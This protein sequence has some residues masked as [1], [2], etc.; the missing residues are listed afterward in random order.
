MML[1]SDGEDGTRRGKSTTASL[2]HAKLQG[3]EPKGNSKV[4]GVKEARE[5]GPWEVLR[6]LSQYEIPGKLITL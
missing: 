2:D 3:N 6:Q 4:M 5:P 1:S